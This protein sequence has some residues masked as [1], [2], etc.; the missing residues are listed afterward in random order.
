MEGGGR[1][2]REEEEETWAGSGAEEEV[3]GV[4]NHGGGNSS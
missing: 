2:V 1:S 3:L 4:K